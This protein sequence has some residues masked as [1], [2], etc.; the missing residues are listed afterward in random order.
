ME[1]KQ[2]DDLN[3]IY[4]EIDKQNKEITNFNEKVFKEVQDLCNVDR[5]TVDKDFKSLLD[6]AELIDKI[7]IVKKP[8][9]ENQF[10]SCG[11][12]TKVYVDQCSVGMSGDSFAGYIYG[13]IAD[14]KWLKVPYEC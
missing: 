4:A 3:A 10:E 12:F 9:G 8:E 2:I 7:E 11:I 13:K 1:Q 14:K 5:D 6:F